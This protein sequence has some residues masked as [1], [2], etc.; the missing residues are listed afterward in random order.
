MPQA[1]PQPEVT[2]LVDQVRTFYERHPYPPPV[3]D[4]ESY[5]R[6]WQDPR[7]RRADHHIFW[8]ARPYRDDASVLI[9]GCGTSQAA[10]HALR[11]PAARVT[12]VDFSATSVRATDALKRKYELRNLEVHQ[13]PIERVRELGARF[14]QIVCTGVLHHLADPDAGL[15]AL[16]DVLAPDG[17][18]HLMVYASYGR[19]G[20]YMI[21]DLCRRIGI[22]A[23]AGGIADLVTM[24]GALPPG[25][26]I[27]A[28][29]RKAPD[30][31]D[32]AGLA[33]ALLHPRD[34]AYSVPE[35]FELLERAG[36]SFGR[37]LRQAPYSP[38]CGVAAR[39]PQTERILRLSLRDQYASVELFRGTMVRH[40]CVVYR[41]VE[42]ASA[43][44]VHFT[45]EAWLRYVP[46]RAPDAICVREHLPPGASAVLINRSH[47]HTDIVLPI[48]AREERLWEAIDGE[49]TIG[50]LLDGEENV[51]VA[52]AFFERM[53]EHDQIVVDTS[54]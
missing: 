48:T 11:W 32:E 5:R 54:R 37:W 3:G 16:R 33:D 1:A 19:T 52:R 8:P 10:K 50:R 51:D 28:L 36:L 24:L 26:P 47:A 43:Q 2:G 46:M 40:S 39:L 49:R 21:Q 14:D 18:M 41:D 30:F 27:E 20:V 7:R 25:H 13:L 9:A 53:Y 35:L 6:L 34:R 44:R 12:G 22:E 4:L 42:A 23:T 17:A 45:G 29:L 31:H 15:A 38:R